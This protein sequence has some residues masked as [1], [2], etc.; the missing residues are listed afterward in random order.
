M[1]TKAEKTQGAGVRQGRA[2]ARGPRRVRGAGVG[3]A[4][5]V[6]RFDRRGTEPFE[7]FRSEFGQNSVRIKE[8]LLH[9]CMELRKIGFP[10]CG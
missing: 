7:L 1:L 10:N 3:V 4:G 8:M 2:A 5:L 6:E 9:V